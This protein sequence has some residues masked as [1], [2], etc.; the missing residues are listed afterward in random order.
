VTYRLSRSSLYQSSTHFI[1]NE[2][3]APL[4]TIA[5]LILG[6]SAASAFAPTNS[7]TVRTVAPAGRYD[8]F[9][10]GDLH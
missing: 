2:K 8:F 7:L 6:A 3:M 9:F 4:R 5:A 10:V 1:F